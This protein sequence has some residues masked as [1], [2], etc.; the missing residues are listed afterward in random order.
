MTPGKV[1][2]VTNRSA[3]QVH[4]SVPELGI[5]SR[6]FQPGETKKI[7][8][9]ELVGLSYLPGGLELLK[10]Y[11]QV[12][13]EEARDDLI[14]A[15][16]PEYNMTPEQVKELILHGSQDEWLDCLDFAPEGVIDLIKKLSVELPLTDTRKM[17][18]FE[19]KTGSNLSRMIQAKQEEEAERAAAEAEAN[20]G[21]TQPA[22]RR[23]Q[24]QAKP[25]STTGT[26][27]RTS[28]SKYKVVN[29][30]EGTSTK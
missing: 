1:Y 18:A 5:K 2:L 24:P 13:N 27:R 12:Q 14:G 11:L 17:A 23:V 15:V 6:D 7:G 4:Y 30:G 29:K 20:E 22:R 9:E 16:E 26:E 19:K 25:T 28:G 3:S 8:H 21:Q 10:E